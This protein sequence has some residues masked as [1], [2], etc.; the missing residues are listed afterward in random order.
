MIAR[1]LTTAALLGATVSASLAGSQESKAARTERLTTVVNRVHAIGKIGYSDAKW[2]IVQK[3]IDTI[4]DVDD[5]RSL[6]LIFYGILSPQ[7]GDES[8]DFAFEAAIGACI[9]KL[10]TIPTE[11]ASSALKSLQPLIGFDSSLGLQEA[12]REQSKIMKPPSP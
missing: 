4:R 8:Y 10:A 7:K 6:V 2:P 12:I 5:L 1:L 3:E 9:R 11:Q